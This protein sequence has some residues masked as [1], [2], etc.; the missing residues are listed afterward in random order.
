MPPQSLVHQNKCMNENDFLLHL[1]LIFS[2]ILYSIQEQNINFII[3]YE[4][5]GS[6][7]VNISSL[8]SF[9]KQIPGSLKRVI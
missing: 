9:I 5:K 8:F 1:L 3:S 6:F 7:T 4:V 2:Y